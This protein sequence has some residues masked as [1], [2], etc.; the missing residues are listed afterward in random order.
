MS[1]TVLDLTND[2]AK[3]FFLKEKNYC[4]V[5]FPK[6]FKFETLLNEIDKELIKGTK[7]YKNKNIYPNNYENVNYRLFTNKDGKYSWRLLELIHPVLYVKLV[8]E[9]TND[10]Q[11]IQN[12]FARFSK[13]TNIICASI[14]TENQNQQI[15]AWVKNVEQKSI[16]LALEYEYLFETD[17]TDCYGAIYTHSIPWAIHTQKIAKDN[18]RDRTRVGNKID[19]LLQAMNYGQ[20][21]GI[22]QGSVLMDFI[23]EMVLGYI[24][25]LLSGKIKEIKDYRIIRYRDD[26]RIFTNSLATG[27][28]IV[29][30]LSNILAEMGMRLSAEKTKQS[31]DIIVNSIKTDKM[32]II[33]DNRPD[34]HNLQHQLL[35]IKYLS[36]QYPNSGSLVTK[37]NFFQKALSKQLNY[38]IKHKELLC[39][40]KGGLSKIKKR[41]HKHKKLKKQAKFFISIL[42]NIALKNPRCHPIFAALVSQI[43]CN[44]YKNNPAK[45]ENSIDLIIKKFDREPNSELLYLWLQRIALIANLTNKISDSDLYSLVEQIYIKNPF[46]RI[47]DIWNSKDWLSDDFYNIIKTNNFI[48]KDIMNELDCVISSDEFGLNTGY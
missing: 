18:R 44:V 30:E 43:I 3:Y 35:Y 1:K 9:I 28:I 16:E 4:T 5:S 25:E 14:P 19:T 17:I 20:T 38:Q 26:Y 32:Q 12:A 39:I 2:Q 29:K 36:E 48:D 37:L 23:A 22:P 31:N 42:T 27:K 6:Y 47:N 8:N 24:D 45:K 46:R 40:R 11:T 41:K 15:N 34:S 33:I 10:W 21:N 13:N 7:I